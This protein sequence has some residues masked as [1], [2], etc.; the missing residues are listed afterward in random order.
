M[1]L[2]VRVLNKYYAGPPSAQLQFTTQDGEPGPPA[3]FDILARGSTHFDLMWEKPMEPNGI[4][5]GFNI[6]YQS[7]TGESSSPLTVIDT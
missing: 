4:L 6:S 7:I 1:L 2:Q 5:T 3:A